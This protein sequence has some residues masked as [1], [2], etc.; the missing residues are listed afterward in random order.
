MANRI[1]L[2]WDRFKFDTDPQDQIAPNFKF[3]E[4]TRSDLAERLDIDNR[5]EMQDQL[6][7]AV[8]LCRHILNPAYQT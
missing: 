8:Y 7:S 2:P 5:F 3:Y 6:Q 1:D 4:L